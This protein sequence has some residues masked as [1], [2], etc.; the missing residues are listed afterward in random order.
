M[1]RNL[2]AA[3]AWGAILLAGPALAQEPLSVGA[4]VE[5]AL[6]REDPTRDGYRYDDYVLEGRAGQRLEATLLADDFDPYLELFVEGA[7]EA[8]AWD[9]DGLGEGFNARLR[10]TLP[11][12]GVYVLRARAL[13][14][15]DGGP[16][17]LSLAERPPAPPAPPAKPIDLDAPVSGALD[18]GDPV[19]EADAAYDAYRFDAAAGERTALTLESED[20]DALLVV[21]R[22]VEGAFVELARNDDGPGLGLNSY[23][24]FTAPEAGRYVVRAMALSGEAAGGYTLTRTTPPPPPP[25]DPIAFG[26]EVE[27]ELTAGDGTNRAGE[28]AD[29][30]AFEAAAGQTVRIGMRSADFDAYLALTDVDGQELAFDD[31]GAG[32]GTDARIVHTFDAAGTYLIEAR[33]FGGEAEGG[34]TLELEDV[35]PPPPPTPLSF[36]Q[37]L[38]GEID[39]DSPEDAEGRRYRDFVVQGEAGRRLQAV[40][41]SGDFDSYLRIGRPGDAFEALAEDDDGLGEGLDSRL[42]FTPEETGEY[43]LRVSPLG[44]GSTGLFA[45]EITDRGPAPQ[46]G[47]LLIGSTV[48][49]VIDENDGL[50]L[51]GVYF[52]A[53]RIR[54]KADEEVRIVMASNDFDAVVAIGRDGEEFVALSSDDDSLSDTH[55]RLDWTAE[56]DGVYVIRAQGFDAKQLGPYIL[57][58]EAKP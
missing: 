52:D 41:R 27:G 37:R 4:S 3:A 23:L 33:A 13:N 55:A 2:L 19:D 29:I 56:E 31:D 49:G 10:A 25:R 30:Y 16:Y 46:P 51:D 36:G 45:V 15:L 57:R 21:G 32:F 38:E 50:S 26:D 58:V 47:S 35:P 14:G 42:M 39:E 43:I 5:A 9:D 7:E 6:T 17:T 12:D 34:Y 28:R 24:V 53:Y 1:R 44:S 40:L 54:L 48:R 18:D 11:E 22:E 8:F 20:F